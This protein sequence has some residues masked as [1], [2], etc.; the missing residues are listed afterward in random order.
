MIVFMQPRRVKRIG[1]NEI[2]TL[3]QENNLQKTHFKKKPRLLTRLSEFIVLLN[4]W[5]PKQTKISLNVLLPLTFTTLLNYNGK[6]K[7]LF[8]LLTSA[9]EFL[10]REYIRR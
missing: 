1:V 8:S 6:I 3:Q 5:F 9:Q 7:S 2:Q 10:R 4:R